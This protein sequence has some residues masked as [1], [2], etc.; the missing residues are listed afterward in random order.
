VSRLLGLFALACATAGTGCFIT[1]PINQRPSI[2]IRQSSGDEVF[3]GDEVVLHAEADDPE[4]HIVFFQWRAYL[5]TDATPDATGARP[6]CDAAPFQSPVIDTLDFTVPKVRADSTDPIQVV[7]VILEAQDDYGATARPRQELLIP[8]G[9]HAPDLDVSMQ[10][11]YGFVVGTPLEVYAKVGDTDDGDANVIVTKTLFQPTSDK[12]PTIEDLNIA[13][14][15]QIGWRFTPAQV[16]RWELQVTATDP[17]GS[18]TQKS[19]VIDVVEDHPPCIAQYSPIAAPIGETWPMTDPTLFQVSVVVD[20]LDPFPR[21]PGDTVLD[22]TKFAWSILPPG[23][24]TRQPLGITGNQAS[25]DPANYQPGD[26]V[27]LRVEIADRVQRTLM[28]ADTTPT[29]SVISDNTCIQRLT[30][31]VEVH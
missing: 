25:L 24:S 26:I 9:D 2:D 7:F 29:C 10:G 15:E 21:V 22:V 5:C 1:E 20:D 18:S 14:P 27:E 8:I 11:H 13:P 28:C 4:G 12:P 16:G 30:W 6:G 23:A 19:A 17:L 31:R 3:R